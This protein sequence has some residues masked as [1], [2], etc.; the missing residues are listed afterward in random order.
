M[1]TSTRG[2]MSTSASIS[3][4]L[5]KFNVKHMYMLASRIRFIV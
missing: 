3:I 1:S 4:G 2:N 5:D